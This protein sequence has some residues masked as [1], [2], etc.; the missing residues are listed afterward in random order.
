MT[1]SGS[2]LRPL[3]ARGAVDDRCDPVNDEAGE[4]LLQRYLN[5]RQAE[6]RTLNFALS[7]GDFEQLRRIGHN[8]LGSGAAYGHDPI[9]RLGAALEV[10]AE[11]RDAV[12]IHLLI[13]DLTAYLQQLRTDVLSASGEQ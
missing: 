3:S 4:Q 5:R 8:L 7:S 10:A 11:G 12:K 13:S 9:S 6:L 2:I 1:D